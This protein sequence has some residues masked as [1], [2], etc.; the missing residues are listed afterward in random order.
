MSVQRIDL[1]Q[2]TLDLLILRTLAVGPHHGWAVSERVQ[3]MSSDV[4]R[5]QQGSLYPALQMREMGIRI[6]LG[7]T[8][9]DIL[10][11]A[12]SQGLRVS[13]VGVGIGLMLAFG[14]VRIFSRMLYGVSAYDPMTFVVVPIFLMA[15]AFL[16]RFVP[17]RRAMQV[18]PSI[19][20]RYE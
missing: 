12:M 5:I 7:A 3:Q 10:M 17:A 6:A 1:P 2:G 13:L 14:V 19:T 8:R 20:L 11:V 16:G 15:V 18:N 9:R 4:L